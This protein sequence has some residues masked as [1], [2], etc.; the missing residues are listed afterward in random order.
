MAEIM[1]PAQ[2]LD[3]EYLQRYYMRPSVGG[4][5]LFAMQLE[6]MA[7]AE[8][9]PFQSRSLDMRVLTGQTSLFYK[10]CASPGLLPLHV[11]A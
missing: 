10:A 1:P 5:S 2:V 4:K 11:S 6:C 8:L 7:D 9:S 3:E